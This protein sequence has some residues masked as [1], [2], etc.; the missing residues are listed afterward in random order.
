M[1]KLFH[2][3]IELW[4][5]FQIVLSPLVIGA[6]IGTVLYFTNP[7]MITLISGIAIA[8]LGLV[9]GVIWATRVRR[10]QGAVWFMSRVMATPELD[11]YNKEKNV[12]EKRGDE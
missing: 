7:G 9:I 8:A 3:I 11:D 5:W 12:E 4:A 1:N 2:A 6:G 10:K